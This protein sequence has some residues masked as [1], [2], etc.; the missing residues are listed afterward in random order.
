MTGQGGQPCRLTWGHVLVH[1]L[2]EAAL[3]LTGLGAR[4]ELTPLVG[5]I[6]LHGACDG[7]LATQAGC[8]TTATVA[9]PAG[10]ARKSP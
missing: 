2:E 6:L 9:G 4:V 10:S 8:A 7:R 5:P 1:P 3:L